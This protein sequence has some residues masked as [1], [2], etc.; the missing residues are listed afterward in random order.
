MTPFRGVR[1]GTPIMGDWSY[2]ITIP[3]FIGQ[4]F[5]WGAGTKKLSQGFY[6]SI[7]ATNFMQQCN[8]KKLRYY[9]KVETLEERIDNYKKFLL[10]LGDEEFSTLTD[11]IEKVKVIT[12]D[13]GLSSV[14]STANDYQKITG[15][16][17]AGVGIIGA[18]ASIAATEMAIQEMLGWVGFRSYV[19]RE[20]IQFLGCVGFLA[21]GSLR[22]LAT[23]KF[24]EDVF[25]GVETGISPIRQ[26]GPSF[27]RDIIISLLTILSAV[28]QAQIV[29]ETHI[30]NPV[31]N[32]IVV[33]GNLVGTASTSFWGYRNLLS[34]I[35]GLR[36]KKKDLIRKLEIFSQKIKTLPES[37]VDLLFNSLGVECSRNCKRFPNY[38]QLDVVGIQTDE[39]RVL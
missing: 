39:D 35:P 9:K 13:R 31:F 33:S 19:S 32:Y 30:Q 4:G 7:L 15:W 25:L 38:T 21:S 34:L 22:G 8:F 3:T 1:A 27:P 24:T 6:Y 26:G 20:F 36:D 10:S 18:W 11:A 5:L 12:S 23:K 16:V 14:H 37:Q 29:L 2:A 17:G 28:G